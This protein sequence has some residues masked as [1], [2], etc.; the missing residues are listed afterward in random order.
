MIV[1]QHHGPTYL[2]CVYV[3]IYKPIET[4]IGHYFVVVLFAKQSEFIQIVLGERPNISLALCS[5][6]QLRD[7]K[8]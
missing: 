5:K 3:T 2:S 6:F 4:V 7:K 8:S 1:R